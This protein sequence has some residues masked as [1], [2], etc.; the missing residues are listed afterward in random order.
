MALKILITNDDGVNAHGIKLLA[1]WAKQ[2]GEVTVVAPKSEQSG[3]SQGIEFVKA[4]EIKEV[5][6]IDGVKAYSV[7]STPADCVRFGIIGLG[8]KYDLALSGLN[9]GENVGADIVYSGT[10]G[11][12]YES[13]RHKSPSIA[14]S[15]F[16]NTQDEACKHFD[17]AYEFIKQKNLFENT[18]MLNVNIPPNPKGTRVTQQG[19]IY[20]SD[21]FI[22]AEGE[23]MYV[24]TGE[25]ISDER[26]D[27]LDRDTVAI[28]KGYIT[29]TPLM[30]L[31]T[32][33]EVFE[34]YRSKN[35]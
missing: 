30:S 26:P 25:I 2:F 22:K 24:Q 11:A 33:M 6:F 17:A 8:Q 15:T 1:Q 20:F 35:E 9:K 16:A 28:H 12:I 31:R 14:F 18:Y 19:G 23:N 5:P 7:D 32:N 29:I 27:D 21:G 3:K 34:K 4:V 10:V 13:S